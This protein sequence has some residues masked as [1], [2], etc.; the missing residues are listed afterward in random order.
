MYGGTHEAPRYILCTPRG[1]QHNMIYTEST[2]Y[3]CMD[4]EVCTVDSMDYVGSTVLCRGGVEPAM[5]K[6]DIYIAV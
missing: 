1:G 4:Y 3:N 2:Y 5:I 6:N